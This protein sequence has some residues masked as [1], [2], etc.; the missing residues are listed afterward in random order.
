MGSCSETPIP[1]RGDRHGGTRMPPH[2]AGLSRSSVFFRLR[3][4]ALLALGVWTV[5]VVVALAWNLAIEQR[6]LRALASDKARTHIQKDLAFRRWATRHGGVYVPIDP[7]TPPNPHLAHVLERDLTTPAGKRLTLMNPAYMLRQL[8]EESTDGAIAGHITSLKLLRPENAP[9]PWEREA[10]LAL[11]EGAAEVIAFTEIDGIPWVRAM[12]PLYI[13]DGCLKCHAHQGYRQG[14]LRGGISASI[15]LTPYLALDAQLRNAHFFSHGAGWLLGVGGIG[16][17][18]R[19]AARR[20]RERL[21]LEASRCRDEE[22]IRRLNDELEQR[23]ADRTAQLT[24]ANQELEAF[25]YSVSHDLRAPL[26]GIDG[27]S[28]AL[29]EDYADTLDMRGRDYL[30]R[31]RGASQR[32]GQLID[33]ILKLSR[34]TRV[35]LSF[36][37]VD[38]SRLAR[39]VAEELRQV[40]PER[41]V[42][43]H[44]ADGLKARGD[45]RL[46]RVALENLIGNAWKFTTGKAGASIEFG[47]AN[48][49]GSK[50]WFVRDDGAGFD[51]SF[52]EK[53]FTPFQRLHAETE[54]PGTGIGL[55]MVQ[56]IVRRHGGRIWAEGEVGKGATFFFMLGPST[57]GS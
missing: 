29:L 3:C 45:M 31:V 51:P 55:S 49:D 54:F 8:N 12:L 43:F 46:L 19:R 35:T 37:E 42:T 9:D 24:A 23:V 7:R 52:S 17:F 38:L 28:Q 18:W 27:F 41:Q 53:L 57:E 6:H 32:M 5:L 47:A 39:E 16:Y 15:S 36:E 21:E 22:E 25:A 4:N 30:R 33:D 10:L 34:I 44:I 1:E 13:E 2:D 11:Q 50:V 40:Q 20:A 56:R 14:D 26:R 48:S